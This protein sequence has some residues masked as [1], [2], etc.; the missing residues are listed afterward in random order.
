[1]VN[2]IML[3]TD[4]VCL[5]YADQEW[6]STFL[7]FQAPYHH[8]EEKNELHFCV[9]VSDPQIPSL[10]EHLICGLGK[11]EK[12]RLKT[13]ILSRRGPRYRSL[14][15]TG[16]T[17]VAL[18]TSSVGFHGQVFVGAYAGNT[19]HS[20]SSAPKEQRL[21]D[22]YGHDLPQILSGQPNETAFEHF[23]YYGRFIYQLLPECLSCHTGRGCTASIMED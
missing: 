12:I 8:L 14:S 1:M 10:F 22:L 4:F 6:I 13:R 7:C 5:V 21:G 19:E 17:R 23:S 3:R 11:P 20:T 16:L 15:Y 18:F 9:L 2:V